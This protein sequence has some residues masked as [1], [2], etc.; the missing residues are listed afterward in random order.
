M[1]TNTT[2][3]QGGDSA[4]AALPIVLPLAAIVAAGVS[5]PLLSVPTAFPSALMIPVAL[6][7]VIIIFSG[8]S[9]LSKEKRRSW[10]H[11]HL[12][13]ARRAYLPAWQQV[14]F[15]VCIALTVWISRLAVGGWL[16]ATAAV[17]AAF[18]LAMALRNAYEKRVQEMKRIND[19]RTMGRTA[20]EKLAPGGKI[21]TDEWRVLFEH[22]GLDQRF[23]LMGIDA[24][25]DG[26]ARIRFRGAPGTHRGQIQSLDEAIC[27]QWGLRRVSE[28]QFDYERGQIYMIASMNPAAEQAE[29]EDQ[30]Y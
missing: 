7:W 25:A 30:W 5:L 11:G 16:G 13:T 21:P 18:C 2:Q 26:D 4:I 22:M 29:P 20:L 8:R 3:Q 24:L 19:A 17:I 12:A 15:A 14:A 10:E 28:A 9:K 23:Q 1:T 6:W 27:H